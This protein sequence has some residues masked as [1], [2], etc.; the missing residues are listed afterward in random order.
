MYFTPKKKKKKKKKLLLTV[1]EM[2]K[3]SNGLEAR[4]LNFEM[5]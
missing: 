5:F 3:T 1:T 4:L 2:R